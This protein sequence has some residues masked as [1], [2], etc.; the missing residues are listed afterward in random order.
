VSS[1]VLDKAH[2]LKWTDGAE[3]EHDKRG[4]ISKD[5][6]NAEVVGTMYIRGSEVNIFRAET[7]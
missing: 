5:Q 4:R 1:A 3:C 6:P 7:E 2:G